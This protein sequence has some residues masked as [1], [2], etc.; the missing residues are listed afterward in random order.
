MALDKQIEVPE[1]K[2]E[3]EEARWWDS[4]PDLL[5]EAFQQAKEK[6]KL[7][8]LVTAEAGARAITVR[9]PVSDVEL[10]QRLAGRKGLSYQDYLKTLIH[11]ALER[12]SAAAR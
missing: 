8:R 11:E 12:E 10:A 6:G 3:K 5:T 1:F 4:H 2:S 9:I 7:K